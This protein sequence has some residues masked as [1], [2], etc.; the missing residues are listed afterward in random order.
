MNRKTRIILDEMKRAG[1]I[2]KDDDITAGEKTN[3]IFDYMIKHYSYLLKDDID[4]ILPKSDLKKGKIIHEILIKFGKYFLSNPQIF[5]DRKKLLEEDNETFSNDD[6]VILGEVKL[7]DEPVI[8]VSNH[9]FKDD[10]LATMLAAKRRS[11]ILFGSLPHFYNTLDG[12]LSAKNGVIM[13]NRKVSS[14]RKTSVDKGKYVLDNGMNLMVF[15]EGVWNKKPNGCMLDFWS[16]FYKLAK[17]ED[18]TFYPIVPIIHYISNTHKPGHDNPI[19][20]IID[21]PIY[22]NGMDE[23]EGIEFIRTRML[24]WYYKLMEM[25]GKTTRAEILDGYENVTEAWEDELRKRVATAARY[26][27]EIEISADK[28]RKDEPLSVWEP[29]SELEITKKNAVEVTKAKQLVKELK[30]NDFQHRF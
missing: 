6:S 11:Y 27:Y 30:R 2:I 8:F 15:P 24:T 26:D 3:F 29:I 19:H 14:S 12:L 7:P 13:V 20:T 21:N 4:V 18:G 22:L 28:R 5:E 9:S 25:Y 10:V 16:G 1:L 17:K 23:K